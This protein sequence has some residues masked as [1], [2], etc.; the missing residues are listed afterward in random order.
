MP[1]RT[2][3]GRTCG[4]TS[5]FTTLP[6]VALASHDIPLPPRDHGESPADLPHRVRSKAGAPW[7]RPRVARATDRQDHL[8][9]HLDVPWTTDADGGPALVE[10]AGRACYQSWSKP[11]PKTATNAG[12]LRHIIDVGH[13]SVLEHA[14]LSFYIT[15]ISRSCTHELIHPAFLSH[16]SPSATRE[17]LAG[18]RAAQHGGRRP[19]PHLTEAAD[20]ARATWRA[21]GQKLESQDSPTNPTIL[22]RRRPTKPPAR[23]CPSTTET[24]IVV[25]GNYGLAALHRNA[26][27]RRHADVKSGDW[28]SNACASSP[29]WPPRCPPTR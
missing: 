22:R 19:A 8:W 12:Y 17:G 7:P 16:L 5:R 4:T 10:L 28:P 11:N 27:Q 23:C 6:Y 1:T 21:A 9:S 13:F 25:T 3:E 18:R 15:G 24:R 14:S 20:A 29:P 26:G 2:L